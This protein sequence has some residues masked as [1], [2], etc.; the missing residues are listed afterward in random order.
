MSG[1]GHQVAP[2]PSRSPVNRPVPPA[3]P[4]A[5]RGTAPAACHRWRNGGRQA[6]GMQKRRHQPRLDQNKNA[7]T[8]E[9]KT[10]KPTRMAQ[11]CRLPAWPSRLNTWLKSSV[12]KSNTS[13][14][15]SKSH[16][17]PLHGAPPIACG[18]DHLYL[19]SLETPMMCPTCCCRTYREK[20][21][22][23]P[24]GNAGADAVRAK[25]RLRRVVAGVRT[26]A[27]SPV[28][29]APAQSTRA[30]HAGSTSAMRLTGSG[31]PGIPRGRGRNCP[32]A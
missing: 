6:T 12:T 26:P 30:D 25:P 14:L 4:S 10:S 13:G 31:F 7:Q 22:V 9:I 23:E 29:C 2:G 15:A 16:G 20:G 1:A 19:R 28:R 3:H 18:S 27:G 8:T 11:A 17:C 21:A 5:V 24:F 32:G